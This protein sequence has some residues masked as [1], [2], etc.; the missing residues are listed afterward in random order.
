RLRN[1]GAQRPA[2]AAAVTPRDRWGFYA[3]ARAFRLGAALRHQAA[4]LCDETLH[5]LACVKCH[6]D[7]CLPGTPVVAPG[8]PDEESKTDVTWSVMRRVDAQV[9]LQ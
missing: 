1:R 7:G 2:M 3:V 8:A 4:E 5:V 9:V 6:H